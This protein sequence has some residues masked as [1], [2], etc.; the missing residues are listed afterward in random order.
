[1]SKVVALPP[2]GW[3]GAWLRW[4]FHLSALAI[5]IPVGFA[6]LYFSLDA[7][8]RGEAGLGQREIG[9]V[10]A[11]PWSVRMAEQYEFA[12]LKDG[13]A[14]YIKSFTIALCDVCTSEVKAAYLKVGKVRSLRAAGPLF[15]G[16]PYRQT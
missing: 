2:T 12:P 9:T 5:L 10:T 14:G 13:D 4:R 7:L 8:E 3:R 15:Y 6:P 16:T 1:M 11:G